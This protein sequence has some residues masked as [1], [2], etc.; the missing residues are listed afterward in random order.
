MGIAT[1]H[2]PASGHVPLQILR[3]LVVKPFW[4]YCN[5]SAPILK[6]LAKRFLAKLIA[7]GNL[8]YPRPISPTLSSSVVLNIV[9]TTAMQDYSHFNRL[10]FMTID[11]SSNWD[12]ATQKILGIFTD[13]KNITKKKNRANRQC[14][15]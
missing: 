7:R 3:I 15:K 12:R 8:T 11:L 4:S 5:L 14:Q 1:A 6:A 2:P 10:S 13:I 9:L